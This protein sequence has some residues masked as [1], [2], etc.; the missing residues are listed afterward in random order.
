[1]PS[2]VWQFWGT[3]GGGDV[4]ACWRAR[5]PSLAPSLDDLRSRW[6]TARSMTAPRPCSGYTPFEGEGGLS[7]RT[8]TFAIVCCAAFLRGLIGGRGGANPRLGP[9]PLRPEPSPIGRFI[10][11]TEDVPERKVGSEM[12]DLLT[13]FLRLFGTRPELWN[14]FGGSIAGDI[15]TDVVGELSSRVGLR[16]DVVCVPGK[17]LDSNLVVS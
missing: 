4:G 8:K 12:S 17:D 5:T 13:D 16:W 7:L 9:S 1:M 10:V 6:R 14:P 11:L 2:V 15:G 3:V